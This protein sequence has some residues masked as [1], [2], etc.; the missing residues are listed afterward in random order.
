VKARDTE[1]RELLPI[2]AYSQKQ[3]SSVSVRMEEL[4][5]I[6]HIPNPARPRRHRQQIT[7]SAGRIRENYATLQAESVNSRELSGAWS[8]RRSLFS[9][10]PR[11]CGASLNDVSEADRQILA[12]KPQYDAA[13]AAAEG[14]NAATERGLTLAE[15]AASS[16]TDLAAN[17]SAVGDMPSP[18]HGPLASLRA[19]TASLPKRAVMQRCRLR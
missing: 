16:I 1:V 14:W 15:H 2:Q 18:L 13:Q 4:T 19:K 10:R 11:T 8:C 7:E 3:L 6:R 9:N 12:E 17:L 5:M